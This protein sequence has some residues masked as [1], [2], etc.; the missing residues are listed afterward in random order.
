MN[1]NDRILIAIA[2]KYALHRRQATRRDIL[3]ARRQGIRRMVLEELFIHLSLVLGFPSMLDGLERLQR[4]W[5][6]APILRQRVV[7]VGRGKAVLKRVYGN[8][9]ARLLANLERLHREAPTWIVRDVYGKVFPRHGLTLREREL[10][11]VTVLSLQHLDRQLYSHLRGLL[12][13]GLRP[14][15]VRTVFAAIERASGRSQARSRRVFR[16]VVSQ[17]KMS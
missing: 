16:E 17:K 5:P 12:R 4:E 6:A 7:S 13:L 14:A 3:R 9:T 15:E 8:Q 2:A 11:T 1:A 10:I